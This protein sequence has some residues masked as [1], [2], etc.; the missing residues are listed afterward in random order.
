MKIQKVNNLEV[1]PIKLD[2]KK[3]NIKHNHIFEDDFPNI[4]ISSSK[5]SGKST[6]IVR[7]VENMA[8]KRRKNKD[9]DLSTTIYLF[10]STYANDT[11][12][13]HLI[14][15]CLKIGI[16]ITIYTDDNYEE[17]FNDL[18]PILDERF[19]LYIESKNNK[20]VYPLSIFIY[21]DI[22][23]HDNYLYHVLRTNRHHAIV[24]I[25]SS[26][27]YLDIIPKCRKNLNFLLIFNIEPNEAEK[28]YNEQLKNYMSYDTFI[29]IFKKVKSESKFNF[30]YIN[31][32]TGEL[33]KNLNYK[34][35]IN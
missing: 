35:I 12:Y 25:I 18:Y 6:L 1:K 26:Q 24:N 21:D 34:I 27:N 23:T 32:K 13:K 15:V 4:F 7:L 16:K 29:N 2:I 14:N 20:F 33:R 9:Y 19:K 17:I 31:T 8:I 22:E 5:G 10:S 3:L 30:L 11:A 28:I